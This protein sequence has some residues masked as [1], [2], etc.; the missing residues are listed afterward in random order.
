M[1]F[2]KQSSKILFA[3]ISTII[4]L[5]ILLSGVSFQTVDAAPPSQVETPTVLQIWWPDVLYTEGH[6]E[7]IDDIFAAYN[8]ADLDIQFYPYVQGDDV[9]KLS[10]TKRVAPNALPHLTLIRQEELA[11][12]VRLGLVQPIDR[13][14]LEGTLPNLAIMGQVN[15]I[16]YGITYMF[17]M[18]HMVYTNAF[19]TQPTTLEELQTEEGT[20]LFPA[21]PISNQN[22]NNLLLSQYLALGGRFINDEGQPTLSE[23]ILITLLSFYAERL[24]NNAFDTNLANYSSVEDYRSQV[25]DE[26]KVLAFTTSQFYVERRQAGQLTLSLSPIPTIDDDSLVIFDGWI[27]VMLTN[28]PENQDKALRFVQWMTET[29]RLEKVAT[30]SNLLP[31]RESALRV[32]QASP[33]IS[34]I[35]NLSSDQ[36]FFIPAR[37]N[38]A[39]ATALQQAFI[40]VVSGNSSP[41]EA[42]AGALTTLGQTEQSN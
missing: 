13:W 35:S 30:A 10:L 9:R 5:S 16:Q 36:M 22:V 17:Q 26:N 7:D 42:V 31:N 4:M 39:A 37:P 32:L 29:D 19:D 18:Q 12:A 41:E 38:A 40:A 14:Q 20:M 34:F 24:E 1:H 11:E 33:Y 8:N 15:E 25:N 2:W 28:V 6:R 21:L 3:A 23:D 27:W